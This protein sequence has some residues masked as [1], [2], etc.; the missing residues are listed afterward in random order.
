MK[1]QLGILP[2]RAMKYDSSHFRHPQE[3]IAGD[4]ISGLARTRKLEMVSQIDTSERE[5]ERG[6]EREFCFVMQQLVRK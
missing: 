1:Q 4:K 3:Q 2:F 6:R 5:R